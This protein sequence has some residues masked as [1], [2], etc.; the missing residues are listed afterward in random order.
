MQHLDRVLQAGGACA[1]QAHGS[2]T[3]SSFTTDARRLEAHWPVSKVAAQ[4]LLQSCDTDKVGRPAASVR[5]PK[6]IWL[7]ALAVRG[8]DEKM[9]C[10]QASMTWKASLERCPATKQRL[11][12]LRL[13]TAF[14]PAN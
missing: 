13:L 5:G 9:H 3:D 7:A 10:C 8:F 4:L 11:R 6:M 1:G 14:L 2:W 12:P